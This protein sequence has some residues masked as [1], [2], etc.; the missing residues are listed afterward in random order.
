[1]KFANAIK[2]IEQ[3]GYTVFP[4]ALSEE[5]I[6]VLRDGLERVADLTP[7]D[8]SENQK[9]HPNIHWECDS[10]TL[11]VLAWKPMIQFLDEL[12]GDEIICTSTNYARSDPEHPGMAIHTDSQP[13]G[14]KIFGAQASAP[15]L[16]RVLYYLDD[17]TAEKAPLRVIPY[18]HMSLHA[19]GNPYNRYESHPDEKV[20]TCKAG[21]AVVIN[22][23]I[24][25]GNG[26]NTSAETRRLFA[27]AYRPAWAGPIEEI[28]DWPVEQVNGLP[29]NVR[30]LFKS[31]NTRK[32]NYDIEN[33]P[34][35]MP[36]EGKG[37]SPD[38]WGPL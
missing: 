8:Y 37:I 38:R 27:V 1:M 28:A 30:H 4:D 17:L 13:Y 5:E 6:L 7:V 2:E 25:H 23:K 31:L 9:V 26:P 15:V 11:S 14:S 36:I 20:I 33:R 22:Q 10:K 24:F 16:V 21:T 12:F 34:A 3:Q 19:D 32:V 35:N 29:E 18:S